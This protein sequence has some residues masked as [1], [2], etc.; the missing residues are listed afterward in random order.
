[1]IKHATVYMNRNKIMKLNT[2]TNSWLFFSCLFRSEDEEDG[3]YLA[4]TKVRVKYGRGKTQKIYEAHIKKTDVDNGEQF[5]LVHY[6]GWNVRSVGL[7][8]A[9]SKVFI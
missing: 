3:D 5:Y 4:G 8:Q 7:V 9:F 6:Y 2:T 1:M